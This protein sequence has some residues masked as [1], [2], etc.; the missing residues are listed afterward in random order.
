[1]E[2]RDYLPWIVNQIFKKGYKNSEH[3]LFDGQYINGHYSAKIEH[4]K[5]GVIWNLLV[6]SMEILLQI[7]Y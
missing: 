5:Y 4:Q 1:M 3:G 6:K 7:N 2:D